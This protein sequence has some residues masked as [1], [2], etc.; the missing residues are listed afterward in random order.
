MEEAVAVLQAH[1][2]KEK[3]AAKLA[4]AAAAAMVTAVQEW[5]IQWSHLAVLTLFR[6]VHQLVSAG[7]GKV[8]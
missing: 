4:A 7:F 8:S 5:V 1:Q 3:N 6:N 2:A